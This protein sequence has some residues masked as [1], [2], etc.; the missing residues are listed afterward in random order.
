MRFDQVQGIIKAK[1]T[2]GDGVDKKQKKENYYQQSKR[3]KKRDKVFHEKRVEYKIQKQDKNQMAG[4]KK[5]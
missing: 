4:E 2:T 3:D 5:E 1:K